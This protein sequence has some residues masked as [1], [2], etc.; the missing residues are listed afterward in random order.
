MQQ[1]REPQCRVEVDGLAC[2]VPRDHGLGE[3]LCHLGV[4]VGGPRL[5]MASADHAGVLH[6]LGGGSSR[7]RNGVSPAE[8]RV[9]GRA[10]HETGRRPGRCSVR[11]AGGPS[12]CG[13]TAPGWRATRALLI[14]DRERSTGCERP[15]DQGDELALEVDQTGQVLHRNGI[16]VGSRPA[17][18]RRLL[19]TTARKPSSSPIISS[20]SWMSTSRAWASSGTSSRVGNTR[21]TTDLRICK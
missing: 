16:T 11:M 4:H 13:P 3:V 7:A 2:D 12:G 21:S 14:G 18:G 8:C 9:A 15:L 20:V 1:H 19:I 10:G 6:R 5:S 17:N